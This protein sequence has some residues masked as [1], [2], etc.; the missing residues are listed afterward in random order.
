MW[1]IWCLGARYLVK[2]NRFLFYILW[3]FFLSGG[4]WMLW[5][6]IGYNERLGTYGLKSYDDFFFSFGIL[7]VIDLINERMV[8]VCV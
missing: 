6:I 3:R 4:L 7:P 1:I 8:K 2:I 5:V